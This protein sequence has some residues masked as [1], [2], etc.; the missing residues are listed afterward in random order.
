MGK[1]MAASIGHP[2][3][4]QGVDLR[5][6]N[7]DLRKE[8]R[9]GEIDALKKAKAVRSVRS[10]SGV[11]VFMSCAHFPPEEIIECFFLSAVLSSSSRCCIGREVLSGADYS[12]GQGFLARN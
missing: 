11:V 10:G 5:L 1:P 4:L 12:L 2:G 3:R 7:F 8:A 9:A 6:D